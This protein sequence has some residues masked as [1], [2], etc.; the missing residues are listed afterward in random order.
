[1]S[2]QNYEYIIILD[3]LNKIVYE[4]TFINCHFMENEYDII[5]EEY[6]EKLQ[7]IIYTGVLNYDQDI[8]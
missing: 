8:N 2:I 7:D 3:G 1:M 4:G 5:S 6:D